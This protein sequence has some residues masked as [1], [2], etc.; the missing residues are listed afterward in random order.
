MIQRHLIM[1]SDKRDKY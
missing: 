1:K